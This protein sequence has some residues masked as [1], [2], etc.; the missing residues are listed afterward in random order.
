M[1]VSM[2]A[3]HLPAH[4]RLSLGCTAVAWH[5]HVEPQQQSTTLVNSPLRACGERV[6]SNSRLVYE[7]LVMRSQDQRVQHPLSWMTTTS[8]WRAQHRRRRERAPCIS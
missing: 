8:R 1:L 3:Q 4:G 2:Q 5:P 7:L 6:S